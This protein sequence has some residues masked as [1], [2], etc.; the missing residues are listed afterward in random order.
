[1]SATLF[2][3]TAPL[4]SSSPQK[5]SQHAD[6]LT[7]AQID[8]S[9]ACGTDGLIGRA[10]TSICLPS[11]FIGKLRYKR[12]RDPDTIIFRFL[13]VSGKNRG[14]HSITSYPWAARKSQ[15]LSCE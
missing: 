7:I 5:K 9:Q 2:T 12:I 1:M 4:V 14:R 6:L 3:K 10:I 8:V 11:S 15:R 13:I